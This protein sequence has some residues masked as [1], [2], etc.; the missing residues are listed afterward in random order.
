MAK[1]ESRQLQWQHKQIRLNNCV[2]CGQPR[3]DSRSVA[4]CMGCL[5]RFRLQQ[6]KKVAC[7]PWRPGGPGRPPLERSA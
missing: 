3:G 2:I 1:I 7:N 4:R 5:R 6:R